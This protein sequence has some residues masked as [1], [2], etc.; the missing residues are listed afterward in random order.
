MRLPGEAWLEFRLEEAADGPAVGAV[1]GRAFGD[2]RPA[3]AFI[4]V[5]GFLDP[6]WKV[7]IEADAVIETAERHM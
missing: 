3:S 7:E 4:V 6:R 5:S 2:V 1:H